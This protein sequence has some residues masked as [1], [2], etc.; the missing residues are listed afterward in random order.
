MSVAAPL[1]IRSFRVCFKLERRIH[2]IDRWRLPLPFGVPLR[3]IG[4]AA[5][6][7]VV[8]GML[9]QLPV[10][11]ALLGALPVAIIYSFFVEYYV[12]GLTGAVKE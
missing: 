7:F 12:S 8:L 5:A 1:Q 10:A 4:Y 11:G 6:A 2:K 9:A 3:G